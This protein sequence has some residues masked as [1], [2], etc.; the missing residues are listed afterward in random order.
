MLSRLHIVGVSHRSVGPQLLA[1]LI[2]DERSVEQLQASLASD[3]T[4]SVLLVTCNRVE[5]VWLGD[6]TVQ[7]QVVADWLMARA[8]AHALPLAGDAVVQRRGDQALR[9]LVRVTAGLDSQLQGDSDILGQVRQSWIGARLAGRSSPAL[10]R[11]FERVIH[12]TRRIRH[13]AEFDDAS[14]TIGRAAADVLDERLGHTWSTRDVLVLGSGAAATSALDALGR[15]APRS[16]GV[17][18]RTDARAVDVARKRTGVHAVSWNDRSTAIAA[19]DVVVF[20]LRA[21]QPVIVPADVPT[22]LSQRTKRRLWADIAMPPNVHHDVVHATLD[23]LS[24]N[25]LMTWR[26]IEDSSQK[27]AELALERECALLAALLDRHRTEGAL[28]VGALHAG[29]LLAG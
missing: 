24:L 7:A 15:L 28:H 5:C 18:S 20:A 25:T 21:E 8:R 16:L 2:P 4:P 29:A 3:G 22:L 10:D 17:C 6:S 27:R 1:H 26:S 23:V 19:S 11:V 14:R 9:H 12:A 13:H